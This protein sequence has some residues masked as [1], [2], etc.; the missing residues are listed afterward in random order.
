MRAFV[1]GISGFV[2][3][4]LTEHLLEKGDQVVGFSTSGAFSEDLVH[5]GRSARVERFDLMAARPAEF[6]DLIADKAPQAIY[7]LAAQSNPRASFDDPRGTWALN[8]GGTLNLLLAVK[9]AGL[10]PK[11]RIVVVGS[12]VCYGDPPPECIPVS[13]SCPLRPN[14]AYSASKA[15]ADLLG[16][17]MHL[18]DGLD[19]VMARPFNHAGPR[20]SSRYVLAT[21]AEQ[22]AEVEAGLKE[23]VEVGNLDVVRDY[24]DV[25]DVVRAYRLLAERGRAGEIYNLGTGKGLKLTD[26]LETFRSL[27]TRPIEVRVDPARVRPIDLP[28]L[29]ADAFKLRRDVGWEPL[30]PIEQT[31]ADMLADARR[32]VAARG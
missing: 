29:V 18:S 6:V 19:V 25:R 15:A 31:L 28:Y 3:G 8:L 20:Q 12:G 21:L 16:V 32:R 9:A 1:T 13:E 14:N 26:A 4:H 5:L 10:Q 24:T 23:A 17:Q 27:A 2:G 30:I 7:H 22:V 11:P